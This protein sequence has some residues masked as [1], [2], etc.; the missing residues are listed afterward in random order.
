MLQGAIA[1][2]CLTAGLTVLVIRL[3]DT[4]EQPREHLYETDDG[5]R[6]NPFADLSEGAEANITRCRECGE[7]VEA[8]SYRVCKS[9]LTRPSPGD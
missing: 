9:C 2:I 1:T 6:A 8:P 7:T 3:G 4:P 5:E